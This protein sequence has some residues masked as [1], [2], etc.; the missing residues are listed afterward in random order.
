MSDYRWEKKTFRVGEADAGFGRLF[1]RS[2]WGIYHD[3]R[4][5]RVLAQ[6]NGAVPEL[7]FYGDE[8][9]FVYYPYFKRSLPDFPEDDCEIDLQEYCDIISSWYYG[10]PIVTTEVEGESQLRKILIEEFLDSFRE[11]CREEK[12]VSEFVRFDPIIE[13]YRDFRDRLGLEL[14]GKTVYVNL[15]E[16]MDKIWDLF[17]GRNRTAIRKAR[18]EPLTVEEGTNLEKLRKFN[19]IYTEEMDR[20]G[21]GDHYRFGVEFFEELAQRLGDQFHF[22]TMRYR[23]RIIGGGIVLESGGTAHDYL[24]ASRPEYWDYNCNNYLLFKEIEWFQEAGRDIFDLQGG[25]PGVFN[26][27][28]AFSPLRGEFHTAGII[29][30]PPIHDKLVSL[31]GVENGDNEEDYFPEYRC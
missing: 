23:D 9:N 10:G 28:K 31:A 17:E 2:S 6:H 18:G 24:R 13:N 11:Y 26:F 14:T 20:K 25:R 12:I 29:H 21:A 15:G 3:P 30:D 22:F 27:K 7:F 16:S 8:E 4:Y 5:L 19:E 1:G